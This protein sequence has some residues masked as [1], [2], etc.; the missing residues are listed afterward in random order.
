MKHFHLSLCCNEIVFLKYK[1]PF[2]YKLFDQIIFVDYDILKNAHSCDGSIEYIRKFPDPE[3]KILLLI[4]FE[5]VRHK[6]KT[7]SGKDIEDYQKMFAYGSKYVANDIDIMWS[8]DM[9]EFFDITLFRKTEEEFKNDNELTTIDCCW[10]TFI[11]NQYNILDE[12]ER[13][14]GFYPP[15]ITKHSIGKIYGHCN[16]RE[17][18]KIL[19]LKED[20]I[21]HFSYIGLERCRN[22]LILYNTRT[23]SKHLQDNWCDFYMNNIKQGKKYVNFVHPGSLKKCIPYDGDYPMDI[24]I[25]N[26]INEMNG[27]VSS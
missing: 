19:T 27:I 16:W 17:Y 25:D 11:Y 21:Y 4:D 14:N 15:R 1:L 6:I 23:T 3:N 9:D 10:K 2:L 13:E 8:T 26:M 20:F 12:K 5:N 22:K 18:G 24:N 7:F